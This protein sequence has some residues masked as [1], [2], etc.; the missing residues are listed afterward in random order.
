MEEKK[1]WY[2]ITCHHKHELG[3]EASFLVRMVETLEEAKELMQGIYDDAA[4]GREGKFGKYSDPK[5]LDESHQTLQITSDININGWLHS[6]T[7]E[8]YHLSDDWE[9]NIF[10]NKPWILD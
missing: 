5:W 10:S 6:T 4:A 7:I 3:R 8:T 9:S 1:L 2:V